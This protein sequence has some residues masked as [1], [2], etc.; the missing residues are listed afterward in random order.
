MI[1]RCIAILLLALLTVLPAAG[2]AL[3]VPAAPHCAPAAH[4]MTLSQ[5]YDHAAVSQVKQDCDQ[6]TF[7]HQMPCAMMGL[8]TM[9]GCMALTG[10]AMPQVLVS[11]MRVTFQMPVV[12]RLDGLALV[13]L[14][15]PPRA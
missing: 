8:C 3:A 12:S 2:E 13:P 10:I 4:V 15:E 9:T 14:F 5:D 6:G 11:G 7:H 1:A